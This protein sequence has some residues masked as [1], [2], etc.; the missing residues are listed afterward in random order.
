[1]KLIEAYNL[2][3][4]DGVADNHRYFA[5]LYKLYNF[6][7]D[8]PLRDY[9]DFIEHEPVHWMRGFP[10]KLVNRLGFA[11]PKTAVIKLLKKP[12]VAE[13][14]GADYVARIHDLIWNT[15]KREADAIL[16]ERSTK[17][18]ASRASIQ[19]IQ[20]GK[21][22]KEGKECIEGDDV[23]EMSVGSVESAESFVFGQEPTP[24]L[25]PLITMVPSVSSSTFGGITGTTDTTD[26][27]NTSC[28]QTK[29]DYEDRVE[30]L[31]SV[32]FKMSQ[33]L[34]DGVA[35]AFRLLVSRV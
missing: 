28:K 12:A 35:D 21:E 10:A 13:A 26:T 7:D 25:R 34:P 18:A 19:V 16:Q 24:P 11:K 33:T 1:M 9:L 29:N 32:L 6:A 31:K 22:G 2:L 3:A 23:E 30:F 5:E 20:E 15:F 8:Q 17:V 4:A 27:T 14:L